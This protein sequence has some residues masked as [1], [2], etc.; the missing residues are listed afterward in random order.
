MHSRDISR[1]PPQDIDVEKAVLGAII[2]EQSSI[3]PILDL[4]KPEI[5]YSPAHMKICRAILELHFNK[6]KIDLLSVTNTLRSCKDLDEVGGA[7]YVSSLTSNIGS[8]SHIVDHCQIIYELYLRRELLRTFHEKTDEVFD[9]A[10]VF[11]IYNDSV[12]EMQSLFEFLVRNDFHSMADVVKERLQEI[13]EINPNKNMNGINSGFSKL[14]DM[15]NGFQPSDYVILGARPSMGKTITALKVMMSCIEVSKRPVLFFSL[16]MSKERIAD[17]ILSLKTGINSMKIASNR[18]SAEEWKV[19]DS[20]A[21]AIKNDMLIIVD[22]GGQTIDDI[23][24]KAITLNRS[25]DFGMITIDYIQ[26]ISYSQKQK[27]SNENLT[28]ISKTVKSIGKEC[29]C[30][31]L[32]LSQLK[33]ND[34]KEPHL[35]DLRD[36]GSLEQDADIVWLL[37]REDYEGVVCSDEQK[38]RIDNLIA[39]NRNGEIGAF[40]TYRRPDWTYIGE[41]EY[42]EYDSLQENMPLF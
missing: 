4:L 6:K 26:L 8:A 35:S 22:S 29:D 37:H 34:S 15:T 9:N 27:S 10:D 16:E 1:I 17:R 39:K 42:H 2:L 36:S 38:N 13:S 31:M 14:N 20:A 12:N 33:R 11:K 21:A 18:L 25:H 5:F 7:F 30:V 19:I 24:N 40:Y 28:F 3:F 23:R 32:V 41:I